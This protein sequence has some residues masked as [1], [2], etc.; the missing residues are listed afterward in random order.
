MCLYA[1]VPHKIPPPADTRTKLLGG[2]RLGAHTCPQYAVRRS[3]IQLPAPPPEIDP[4]PRRK[5]PSG[6]Q[7][8]SSLPVLP[9][10]TRKNERHHTPPPS[11][12]RMRNISVRWVGFLHELEKKRL[13]T[14]LVC[15]SFLPPPFPSL[16]L[17]N[18]G[19]AS[20]FCSL[21]APCYALLRSFLSGPM[22]Q[23]LK[24]DTYRVSLVLIA[25]SIWVC[26]F[27]RPSVCPSVR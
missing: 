12:Q 24:I 9:M 11:G 19:R 17:G 8:R 26:F 21:C 25:V 2:S 15:F 27:I 20:F 7:A 22:K 1:T 6:M 3:Q 10:G 4:T 13:Q 5:E 16:G 18:C 23:F 14:Y